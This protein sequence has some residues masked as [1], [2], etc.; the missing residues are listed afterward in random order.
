M[1]NEMGIKELEREVARE[2]D[3]TYERAL[4]AVAEI[5]KESEIETLETRNSDELDFYDLS[6]WEIKKMLLAAYYAGVN[7]E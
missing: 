1:T 6:V 4:A 5:A 2:A 7:G 3:A